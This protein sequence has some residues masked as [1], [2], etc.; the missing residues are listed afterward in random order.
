MSTGD[1]STGCKQIDKISV[2]KPPRSPIV[3][4]MTKRKASSPGRVVRE[5]PG[6]PS[7]KA[8]RA[9]IIVCLIGLVAVY[10]FAFAPRKVGKPVASSA[11]IQGSPTKEAVATFDR[12]SLSTKDR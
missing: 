2:E 8:L 6:D 9:T 1:V 4:G 11:T 3:V 5:E 10:L 7:E 12:S